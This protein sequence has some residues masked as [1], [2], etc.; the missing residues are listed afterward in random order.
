[1]TKSGLSRRSF[2]TVTAGAAAGATLARPAI[3]QADYP[4]R[5]IRLLV[6]YPAG[7][8]SDVP[9]RLV[10]SGMSKF[11]GQQIVVENRPGAGGN[12]AT[13]TLFSAAPDGYSIMFAA[14]PLATNPGLLGAA[15]GYEPADLTMVAQFASV[16]VS[17][18]CMANSP[19]KTMQDVVTAAR[20]RPGALKFSSGGIGTSSHIALEMF[21]RAFDISLKHVPYKGAVPAQQG[22]ES[23]ETDLYF[24]I[25]SSAL[26]QNIGLGRVRSLGVMQDTPPAALPQLPTAASQGVPASAFLRSWQGFCV[27]KGTPPAI[28]EKLNASVAAALADQ[29]ITKKIIGGGSDIRTG[30]AQDFQAFYESELVRYNALI[31]ATGMKAE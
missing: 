28:I 29:E 23:G 30:S 24:E 1:M 27:R 9:A 4:S 12:L 7:G 5:P 26:V 2:I 15:L 25:M 13:Q 31:K 3:A 20:A 6:G 11:L 19:F 14:I 18:T 17:L 16:P 21:S 8:S 10:A 22:L